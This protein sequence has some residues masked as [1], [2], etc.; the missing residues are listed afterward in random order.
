MDELVGKYIVGTK[1]L[2]HGFTQATAQLPSTLSQL[3]R[4]AW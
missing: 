3:A 2:R 1:H 4:R